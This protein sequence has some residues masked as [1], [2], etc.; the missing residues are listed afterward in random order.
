MEVINSDHPYPFVQFVVGNLLNNLPKRYPITCLRGRWSINSK[1]VNYQKVHSILFSLRVC[2]G[3]TCKT[4][5]VHVVGCPASRCWY[6]LRELRTGHQGSMK[7]GLLSL[8][9]WLNVNGHDMPWLRI[10]NWKIWP[11]KLIYGTVP[12]FYDP[13][14]PIDKGV[15]STE[16]CRKWHC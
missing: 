13:E 1:L 12:T 4:I 16:T 2:L 10:L 11:Y 7:M 8:A 14:I 6:T 5:V 9:T 3:L 15:Y